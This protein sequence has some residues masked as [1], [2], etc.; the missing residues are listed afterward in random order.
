MSREGQSVGFAAQGGYL[1]S[2]G[3][4]RNGGDS[5]GFCA[6]AFRSRRNS[7]R[8]W[9]RGLK[10][11]VGCRRFPRV[12]K[13]PVGIGLRAGVRRGIGIATRIIRMLGGRVGS[14]RFER[15]GSGKERARI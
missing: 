13:T 12:I 4:G 2:V 15:D 3:A 7:A 6:P 10:I 9:G 11:V 5:G 14:I 8:E 1:Q